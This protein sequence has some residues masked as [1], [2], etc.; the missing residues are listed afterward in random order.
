MGKPSKKEKYSATYCWIRWTNL[1]PV[2]S[3]G[4]S[5]PGPGRKR[6]RSL[7]GGLVWVLLGLVWLGSPFIVRLSECST[8]VMKTDNDNIFDTDPITHLSNV[9]GYQ[10]NLVQSDDT[11]K[12]SKRK[13]SQLQLKQQNGPTNQHQHYHH[14][15][16]HHPVQLIDSND[17]PSDRNVMVNGNKV[18]QIA[19]KNSNCPNCVIGLNVGDTQTKSNK[20]RSRFQSSKSRF[21]MPDPPPTLKPI[22]TDSLRLEA[23][24]QQILSKL[25]L[26]SKPNITHEFSKQTILNTLSRADDMNLQNDELEPNTRSYNDYFKL[27]DRHLFD[28]NSIHTN[29][30]NNNNNI[31][32]HYD[33]GTSKNHITNNNMNTTTYRDPTFTNNHII[34]DN[35]R[36]NIDSNHYN[37]NLMDSKTYT[38]HINTNYNPKHHITQNHQTSYHPSKSRNHKCSQPD[39]HKSTKMPSNHN[40]HRGSGMSNSSHKLKVHRNR[41]TINEHKDFYK[42]NNFSDISDHSDNNLLF[43]NEDDSYHIDGKLMQRHESHQ[44]PE[45]LNQPPDNSDAEQDDYFGRTREVITFAEQGKS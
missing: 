20:I 43:V 33:F 1:Y 18:N 36:I 37:T 39:K 5:C 32:N 22:S 4:P 45:Q 30:N 29:N 34:Q 38:N 28:S 31:N 7:A 6:R 8:D 41:T 24:K 12:F 2:P 19:M 13:S 44:Q 27:N 35:D 16:L 9:R 3:P 11:L 23:I 42:I 15:H 26:K 40:N 14:H 25:G 10:L 17:L 21:R